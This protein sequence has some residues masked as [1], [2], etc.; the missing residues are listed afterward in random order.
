MKA[1]LPLLPVL[2]L[3]ASCAGHPPPLPAPVPAPVPAAPAH[4][5]WA[6]DAAQS[7]I[8]VTVRRGGPLARLGHDHVVASR[9]LAGFVDMDAGRAEFQF[10]L[11]QLSVDEAVL[12]KQAGLDTEPSPDAIAGTR[13]NMLTKVLDAE[14]YPLV[15]MK[16]MRKADAVQMDVTL[17]GV[18]RTIDVPVAFERGEGQ[19]AAS[20]SFRLRQSDFG[21]VPMSVL[22]GAMVVKDEMELK[23]RIVARR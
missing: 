18:T 17:H 21:I 14:H 2:L 16:A 6:I 4:Q 8:T 20:G 7:L 10:R 13:S 9:T 15:R 22:G 5:G 19:I 1:Y 3:L 11:D 12:R 23:F